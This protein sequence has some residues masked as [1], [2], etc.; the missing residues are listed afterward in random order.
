MKPILP[1]IIAILATVTLTASK[2]TPRGDHDTILVIAPSGSYE[3]SM[4]VNGVP[5]L[6]PTEHHY[7]QVIVLG[8]PSPNP[9][10]VP[11]IPT[12]PPVLSDRAK[13]FKTQAELVVE[14][15]RAESAQGLAIIYKK[16]AEQIRLGVTKDP[17]VISLALKT[18]SDTLLARQGSTEAWAKF[19]SV[20]ST[21]WTALAASGVKPEELALFLEDAGAGLDASAPSYQVSP[22]FWAFLLQVIQLILTLLKPTP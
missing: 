14:P 16:I 20:L 21:H 13:M 9:T 19:R 18:G 2:T 3:L 8:G 22:E 5:I 15:K 12:P 10:P 4:D 6:T 11:P 1:A 7:K 17:A